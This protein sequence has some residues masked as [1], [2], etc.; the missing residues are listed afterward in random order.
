MESI[1]RKSIMDHMDVSHLLGDV[2]FGFVG[3]NFTVLQLLHMSGEWCETR[4]RGGTIDVCYMDF[5]KA[6]D[7]VPHCRLLSKIKSYGIQGNLHS[8]VQDFLSEHCQKVMINGSA[9]ERVNV[10]SGVPQGSVLE[11]VL[12]VLCI[13][14]L[15]D[16]VR[17]RIMLYADDTKIY[18][19]IRNPDYTVAIQD[20][21][22]RMEEWSRLWLLI[23]LP[24]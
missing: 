8:W 22:H 12:F 9:S 14:D 11:P 7:T 23:F 20:D 17:S 5:T 16:T 19:E 24:R 18:K 21:I 10:L 3:R 2:Q 6:F 13:N 4:N 1:L 15:P